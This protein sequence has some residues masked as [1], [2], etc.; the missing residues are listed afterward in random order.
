MKFLFVSN[1]GE[2]LS[3]ASRVS[4]EGHHTTIASANDIGSGIVRNIPTQQDMFS[5]ICRESPDIVV[6][7]KSTRLNSS[8]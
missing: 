7:R 5:L 2:Q 8:H 1:N 3:L 4:D 6:D